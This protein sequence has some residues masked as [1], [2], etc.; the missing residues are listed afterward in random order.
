MGYYWHEIG[1]LNLCFVLFSRLKCSFGCYF[2]IGIKK[3]RNLPF[4]L[5]LFV[6]TLFAKKL[7][8]KKTLLIYYFT[9]ILGKNFKFELPGCYCR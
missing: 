7:F 6:G 8:S 1:C 2:V 4:L 5:S 3:F 9:V